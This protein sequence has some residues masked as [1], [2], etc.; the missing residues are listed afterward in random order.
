MAGKEAGNGSID[1]TEMPFR[2]RANTSAHETDTEKNISKRNTLSLSVKSRRRK[3]EVC[4]SDLSSVM[5]LDI[6]QL[7]NLSKLRSQDS[8]TIHC[9][10]GATI[11]GCSQVDD[12]QGI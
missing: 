6:V 4:V 7:I 5:K 11:C 12:E 3:S 10:S 1:M 2:P 8:E 9:D